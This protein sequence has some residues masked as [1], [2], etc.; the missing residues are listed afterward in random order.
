MGC[1]WLLCARQS[2]LPH[3]SGVMML[4]V[5]CGCVIERTYTCVYIRRYMGTYVCMYVNMSLW[6][7]CNCLY[8]CI[9]VFSIPPPLGPGSMVMG[10]C[11]S[12]M[13]EHLRLTGRTGGPSDKALE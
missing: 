13:E 4:S 3:S 9:P 10:C 1:E 8:V 6:F 12:P 2:P 11:T 5:V 7:L